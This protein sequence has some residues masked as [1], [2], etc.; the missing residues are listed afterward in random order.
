MS[1]TG[2]VKFT[3]EHVPVELAAFP[4]WEEL[5]FCRGT[6]RQL[7]LIGVEANGIGFGN[8]SVR[9]TGTNNFYITGSGSSSVVEFQAAH[10]AKVTAYDFGR[11]W[12]RCEGTMVASSE[13]LTHAAIYEADGNVGAVIHCHSTAAWSR[14]LHVI[15]TTSAQVEYGTPEMA[16]EVLNLFEASDVRKRKIFVM[17]GHVDGIVAFGRDI[18]EALDMISRA[19]I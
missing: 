12:L 10:C 4:G 17:A 14:L 9:E 19:S 11:N 13:S 5:N 18:K 7:G 2:A 15:P 8:L 16:D 6:L 3:C 1:E